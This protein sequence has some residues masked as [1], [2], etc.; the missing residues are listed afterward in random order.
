MYDFFLDFRKKKDS[1]RNGFIYFV[2]INDL[3]GN[4]NVSL[5]RNLIGVK[6]KMKI[7]SYHCQSL[8]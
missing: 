8:C 1:K 4:N 2:A 7:C 3:S 6:I 5:G